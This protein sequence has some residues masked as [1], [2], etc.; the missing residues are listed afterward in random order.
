MPYGQ[1]ITQAQAEGFMN[2]YKTLTEATLASAKSGVP[3]NVA[4]KVPV[5]NNRNFAF[6][7]SK[8]LMETI[9]NNAEVDTIVISLGAH[10]IDESSGGVNFPAGS[11][12]V[13]AMG[14]KEAGD[15]VFKVVDPGIEFPPPPIELEF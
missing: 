1:T 12:T 10:P 3:P 14:C 6:V 9:C 11:F 13:I 4:A 8:S 2:E 15:G 5:F 7:F